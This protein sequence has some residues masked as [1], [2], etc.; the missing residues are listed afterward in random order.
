MIKGV[1]FDLDGVLVSTDMLHYKAWKWLADQLGI[2]GFTE[3]DNMRQRGVSRMASLEV[4]LEKG[5]RTYSQAEKEKLAE[6]KNDFYRELLKSLT[7]EDVLPGALDSLRKLRRMGVC[8]GV[9]SV[10]RNTPVI[11]ERTGLGRYVDA[12]SCGLDITHSKPH[13]EVFLV[14][15]HKLALPPTACLVVEDADAGIQAAIA[16]GM[17]TLGVGPA[18]QNPDADFRAASLAEPVDWTTVL[19]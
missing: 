9:G 19:G 18:A 6:M 15:A 4:V 2:H 12:V 11:L 1:I 7:P 13:P 8:I 16:A 14:A 10:S 17:R 3:A 5:D